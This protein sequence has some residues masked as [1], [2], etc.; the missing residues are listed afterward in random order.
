MK[1][2]G[3][4]FFYIKEIRSKNFKPKKDDDKTYLMA[5]I[6]NSYGELFWLED[7]LVK[8]ENY[9]DRALSLWE[10][11]SEPNDWKILN[12]KD[13]LAGIYLELGN[14]SKVKSLAVDLYESESNL[15]KEF[16]QAIGLSIY[17]LRKILHM[18]KRKANMQTYSWK[19]IFLFWTMAFGM[20]I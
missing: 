4:S 14:F 5:D 19:S 3:K 6:Y 11:I 12:Q 1:K 10:I 17:T 20:M 2:D 18:A 15:G 16:Y 8:S 13:Y 9:H 7:Q